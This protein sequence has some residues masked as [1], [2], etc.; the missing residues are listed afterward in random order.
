MRKQKKIR[1]HDLTN[2]IAQIPPLFS[3]TTILTREHLRFLTQPCVYKFAKEGEVLYV[4]MSK[5]GILRVLCNEHHAR[6]ARD[7]ADEILIEWCRSESAA[8]TVQQREIRIYKPP[9][10][11]LTEPKDHKGLDKKTDQLAA[12]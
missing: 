5:K 9:Y 11:V 10:N 7:L 12:P 8:R 6:K 1:A 3:G 4:G 2:P